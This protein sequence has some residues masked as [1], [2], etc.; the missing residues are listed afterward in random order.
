VAATSERFGDIPILNIISFTDLIKSPFVAS[1]LLQDFEAFPN[2]IV[3]IVSGDLFTYLGYKL[4]WSDDASAYNDLETVKGGN[5]RGD[6]STERDL[7]KVLSYFG[8][9]AHNIKRDFSKASYRQIEN[10][11]RSLTGIDFIA[12]KAD[13]KTNN[14]YKDRYP[15]EFWVSEENNIDYG[16]SKSYKNK[17]KNKRTR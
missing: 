13:F 10:F 8:L 1:T 12:P 14:G 16:N 3:D 4:G 9:N 5:Y 7:F 11:Y 15:W 6:K 2:L 17:Q